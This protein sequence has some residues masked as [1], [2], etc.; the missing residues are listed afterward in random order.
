[1]MKKRLGKTGLKVSI[2]GF[3]AIK[4][5]LLDEESSTRLLNRALD[6]GINFFDTARIY[7]DSEQKIGKALSERRDEFYIS[8]KSG[9]RAAKG[10]EKDIQTSLKNLH[11]DHIDLYMCHSLSDVESYERVMGQ[12]GVIEALKK[13]K[14]EGLIDHIGFSCHRSHETMELGIKSGVFE[15]IMVSYNVLNDELVDERIMPLAKELDVGIVV[16]KPFAGGLLANPP[17]TFKKQCPFLTAEKALRFIL[18]NPCVDTVIPGMKSVEE[19]EANVRVGET[20]PTMSKTEKA[21]L[22]KAVGALGKEFC[23]ACGYC[24]PC[25]Q[26]IR[27][28]MILRFLS[29]FKCYGLV[30]WARARYSMEAVKADACIECRQ[31]IEKCPYGLD[32]PTMLKEAH[33][34]LS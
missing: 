3:G 10:M 17:P 30:K 16:M 13:A 31:C 5:P 22:V 21:E 32:V 26:R 34:L 6:L 11:T 27:I 28:P 20:F 2:V 33:K 14:R 4:L 1:M 9:A 23:R 12:G 7:G 8:T 24:L 29:Y 15:V 25:P 19:L 18:A